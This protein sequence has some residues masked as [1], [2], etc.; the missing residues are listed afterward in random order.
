MKFLQENVQTLATERI[1]V[2]YYL[3]ARG[4]D[5]E[6]TDESLYRSIIDQLLR[7][8]PR[9]H[10]AA[11]SNVSRFVRINPSRR[12]DF[13]LRQLL[14]DVVTSLDSRR[15]LI[16]IDALD[17]C[18]DIAKMG[19]RFDYLSDQLKSAAKFAGAIAPDRQKNPTTVHIYGNTIK[20]SARL[21]EA[22][23]ATSRGTNYIIVRTENDHR[24][25]TE[26]LE[27]AGLV[28]LEQHGHHTHVCFYVS[29]NLEDLRQLRFVDFVDIHRPSVKILSDL[30]IWINDIGVTVPG[31]EYD[32]ARTRPSPLPRSED[33]RAIEGIDIL[34]QFHEY[35]ASES[36]GDDA[37]AALTAMG[38]ITHEETETF[39]SHIETRVAYRN[40]PD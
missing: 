8:L 19:K 28:L 5:R 26:E 24:D 21:G 4:T 14:D 9:L 22:P 10:H 32:D 25:H 37:A 40:I 1:V 2:G 12:T 31:R 15:I 6:Q 34:I 33:Q 38:I 16:Y 3:N 20:V 11:R 29:D 13:A 17:E 35:T 18:K 7:Q 27:A 36:E 30:K 23:A 39:D